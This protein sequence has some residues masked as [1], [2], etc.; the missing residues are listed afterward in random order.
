MARNDR[1]QMGET[2]GKWPTVR[3]LD[4]A[5]LVLISGG[6]V[7][8]GNLRRRRALGLGPLLTPR[9]RVAPLRR[10]FSLAAHRYGH[11]AD[12]RCGAAASK[13]AT[14]EKLL[15]LLG[16]LVGAPGIEP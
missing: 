9:R 1:R 15:I 2:D 4:R 7:G 14:I 13:R 3:R 11:R 12:T 8:V 6:C 16:Y 10:G 5:I